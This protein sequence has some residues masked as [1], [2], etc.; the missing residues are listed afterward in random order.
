[1]RHLFNKH[2]LLAAVTLLL[3]ACSSEDAQAQTTSSV[4]E[5]NI[6]IGSKTFVAEIE[7]T[8]T[9]RAFL[10]LL[11][12]RLNMSEL[13]GNEKYY[14]L[15]K[16]LPT[17]SR[18]YDTIHAGDLMLYGGS[19]VV[20]FYGQAGGYSYTRLGKLK[21]TEG[22]ASAVG[23]GNADV[24]FSAATTGT[25][26]PHPTLSAKGGEERLYSLSGQTAGKPMKGIYIKNGKK[27]IQ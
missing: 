6:T 1:M 4:M 24:T 16:S 23:S 8:E 20:L 5:I 17:S 2:L 13:N 18:H 22:L 3:A 25:E 19:C 26:S 15:D 14:Y 7:D 21:S 9:G 27:Y 11:P 10:S 12:M